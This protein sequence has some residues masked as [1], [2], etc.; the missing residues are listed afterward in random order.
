MVILSSLSLHFTEESTISYSLN[1]RGQYVSWHKAGAVGAAGQD[2]CFNFVNKICSPLLLLIS[3]LC[4]YLHTS[5]VRATSQ[6][7]FTA[8]L[9]EFSK[10][11]KM[12]LYTVI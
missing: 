7:T 2:D 3:P 12:D 1:L 4:R 11:Q 5:Q 10:T 8:P 6:P 9:R